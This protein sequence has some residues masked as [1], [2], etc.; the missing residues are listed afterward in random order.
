MKCSKEP[1][2][3]KDYLLSIFRQAV[4][5]KYLIVLKANNIQ[6]RRLD[7]VRRTSG[8]ISITDEIPRLFPAIAVCAANDKLP[9]TLKINHT[10]RHAERSAA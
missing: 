2:P 4:N 3:D 5:D 10:Y 6:D 7:R 8:E 1:G 9:Y